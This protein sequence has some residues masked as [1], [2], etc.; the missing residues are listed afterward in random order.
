[1]GA[2]HRHKLLRLG[3]SFAALTVADV[4]RSM[5]PYIESAGDA[6]SF[7]ASLITSG[8]LNATLSHLRDDCDSTMLHF[9]AAA[10]RPRMLQDTH[11]QAQLAQGVQV[12]RVLT[13]SIKESNRALELNDD[14]IDHLKRNQRRA[15]TF[16][17][18]AST[19]DE[20]I[21]GDIH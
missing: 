7:V 15:E 14:Y 1:M 19:G 18:R 3:R 10:P 21:M 11:V 20:D 17:G 4:A 9:A 2:F 12:L 13:G 6:E 8:A 16:K 5:S